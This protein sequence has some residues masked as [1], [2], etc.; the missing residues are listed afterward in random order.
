VGAYSTLNITREDAMKLILSKVVGA[1]DGVLED[2]LYSLYSDR[3][4]Y[5]YRIV[6]E[7]E[8]DEDARE[9]P[10]CRWSFND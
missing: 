8:G 9:F 4:L 1:P 10:N 7:Y 2:L 3:L 6:S 5:N